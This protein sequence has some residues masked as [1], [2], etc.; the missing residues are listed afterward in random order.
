MSTLLTLPG[1]T[2]PLVVPL[3]LARFV[4]L[5]A[6]AASAVV[7]AMVTFPLA[8]RLVCEV[9]DDV[10]GLDAATA[11]VLGMVGEVEDVVPGSV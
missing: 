9:T 3:K 11:E 7:G 4:L 10:S 8:T 1:L 5:V 2:L 6:S